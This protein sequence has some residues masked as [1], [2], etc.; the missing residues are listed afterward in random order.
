MT[1]WCISALAR[2]F[3]DKIALG[4]ISD[5]ICER[6]SSVS[7]S[8][9]WYSSSIPML[10]LGRFICVTPWSRSLEPLRLW[11]PSVP[12]LPCLLRNRRPAVSYTH[13]RAH[14]TDSYLVC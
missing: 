10:R 9:V 6:R 3:V 2:E 14:E 5:W 13:L 12:L 11:Q 7:G 4:R 8:I 1:A